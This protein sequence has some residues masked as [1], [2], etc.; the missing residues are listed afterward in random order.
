M[1][2]TKKKTWR[3]CLAALLAAVMLLPGTMSASAATDLSIDDYEDIV[4]AY[5]VASDKIGYEEYIALYPESRPSAVITADAADYVRYEEGDA[6]AV[7]EIYENYEGMEGKSVLTTEDSLI[8]FEITV[9][10]TGYYD[11]SLLYYPVEGKNSAIQRSVFLDG[12]LPYDELSLVE[13]QRVWAMD[14]ESSHV[15]EDGVEVRDWEYDNQ[16]NNLK[17]TMTEVP[18][19]IE[20][21]VYDSEGYITS[22][23]A[24]Y[25]TAGTHTITI[26]GLREPML[27]RSVTFAKSKL[28][29]PTKMMWC[30]SIW[31]PSS[32]H[33]GEKRHV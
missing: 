25:L 23:M 15:N 14:V 9:P 3:R 20:S 30:L 26:T 1:T 18:E 6:A 16:G 13:F 10:E 11:M 7:P 31:C 12:A 8:E 19:W 33:K 4:S 32:V 2:G 28:W 5:A 27:L 21:Y 17:P 22:Q 24:L 29:K